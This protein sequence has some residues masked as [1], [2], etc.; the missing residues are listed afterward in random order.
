MCLLVGEVPHVSTSILQGPPKEIYRKNTWTYKRICRFTYMY[1]SH[2]E[3]C[4]FYVGVSKFVKQSCM[5]I[6][7]CIHIIYA[8][9]FSCVQIHAALHAPNMKQFNSPPTTYFHRFW[10]FFLAYLGLLPFCFPL[11]TFL[12]HSPKHPQMPSKMSRTC[13]PSL[14]TNN[15]NNM[16]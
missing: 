16:K 3:F 11:K 8:F 15:A 1:I 4:R 6:H 12:D 7:I 2:V 10:Q 13:P 5:Y 14:P 9:F